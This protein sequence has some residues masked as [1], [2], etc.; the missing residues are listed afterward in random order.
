[1]RILSFQPFSLYESGGGSR[2]LRRLYQGHEDDVVSLALLAN[3]HRIKEGPIP[4]TAITPLPAHRQWMKWYLRD[5]AAWLRET[6]FRDQTAGRIRKAAAQYAFDVL[7]VVNHGPFSAALC[8]FAGLP[9]SSLWASFHDHFSTSGSSL[10]DAKKL[11]NMA[12]RRL[13]ISREMGGEYRRLLGE[14]DFEVVTDGVEETEIA[15]AGHYNGAQVVIYFAGLLHIDYLPLFRCLADALDLLASH[16]F[17]VKLVLRGTQTLD[18]LSGRSFRIE[19]LPLTLDDNELKRELNAATLLYLPIKFTVPAFYRYSLSTKMVGYLGSPGHILYHGPDD[20]AA[21]QM[22]QQADAAACCTSL[23]KF[24]M[25]ASL[26]SLLSG[27]K[28][29]SRNA[30]ALA[31]SEFD[32]PSLRQRFWKYEYATSIA[33]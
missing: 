7:H 14:K 23:N 5:G 11:W 2:I 30:K 8:D 19:Y 25:L 20:S 12:D 9:S 13:V 29:Y 1:M 16:G 32:L 31:R 6:V 24:E 15:T 26:K 27:R 10:Q 4:E 3:D 22:L 28:N 18:F 33:Q 17:L 21:S